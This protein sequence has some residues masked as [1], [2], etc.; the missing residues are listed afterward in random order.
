M[1]LNLFSALRT[2]A[3]AGRSVRLA[4]EQRNVPA[5]RYALRSLLSRERSQLT[6][7]LAGAATIESLAENLSDWIEGPLFSYVVFGLPGAC[8]HCLFNT[9]SSVICHH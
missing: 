6:A 3:Q 9:S 8:A 1:G 4:L 7:R 2:L 5:A